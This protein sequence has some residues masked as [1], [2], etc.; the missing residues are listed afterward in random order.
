M[1]KEEFVNKSDETKDFII[2]TM[3][4]IDFLIEIKKEYKYARDNA[5][6]QASVNYYNDRISELDIKQK[7]LRALLDRIYRDYN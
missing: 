2:L 7:T 5:I 1:L 4:Y 6:S 3:N